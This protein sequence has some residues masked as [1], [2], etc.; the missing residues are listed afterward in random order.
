MTAFQSHETAATEQG[1]KCRVCMLSRH[2]QQ[3]LWLCYR[4]YSIGKWYLAI[5]S[6]I[7]QDPFVVDA[8]IG[9]TPNQSVARMISPSGQ[10]AQTEFHVLD[11]N[12]DENL[13]EEETNS[14]WYAEASEASVPT[15]GA[16]LLLCRPKTGRTHQIRV[17]LAHVGNPIIG[18]EIYGLQVV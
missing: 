1:C 13:G 4:N 14:G 10:A 17:H 8:P 6:G 15:K 9:R 3:W 18:D 5:V 11:I 16:A 12:Q 2:E 7:L